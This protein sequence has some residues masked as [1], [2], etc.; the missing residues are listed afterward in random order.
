MLK[1]LIKQK[2]NKTDVVKRNAFKF[3]GTLADLTRSPLLHEPF[4][5]V[6]IHE[7]VFYCAFELTFVAIESSVLSRSLL[8][9]CL[10]YLAISYPISDI[11]S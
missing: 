8:F 3:A 4:K 2:N 5:L 9:F 10:A 7:N 11:F 1:K 6:S